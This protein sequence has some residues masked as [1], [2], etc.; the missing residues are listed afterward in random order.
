MPLVGAARAGAA[1]TGRTGAVSMISPTA[2]RGGW[3]CVT[4]V[5][6]DSR[7]CSRS[8]LLVA[9]RG[10]DPLFLGNAA[11]LFHAPQRHAGTQSDRARYRRNGNTYTAD[12]L[13]EHIPGTAALSACLAKAKVA[14]RHLA[15]H[16]PLHPPLRA[17]R[18]E[19]R[20]SERAQHPARY[21][22]AGCGSS[23]SIARV[24]ASRGCG[25]MP[26]WRVSTGPLEK[27]SRRLPRGHFQ[28]SDWQ[29]LLDGYMSETGVRVGAT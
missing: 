16:R 10:A 12:L 2:A 5:G 20:G 23:T 3:C 28:E 13:M 4:T 14:C 24:C 7:R 6:A 1:S 11:A 15:R 21:P 17:G 27:V 25:R 8:T 9:G 18:R 19:P 22:V 29:A 26:A